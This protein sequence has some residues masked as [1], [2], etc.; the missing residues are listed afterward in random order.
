MKKNIIVAGVL[1]A[2]AAFSGG[3]IY[4]KYSVG[5]ALEDLKAMSAEDRRVALS[6]AGVSGGSMGGGRTA[7]AD[8][9]TGTGRNIQGNNTGEQF[10]N[11]EVL[12]IDEKSLTI[13]TQDGGSKIVYISNETK[14]SK[15]V[16]GALTDIKPQIQIVVT[17]VTNDTGVITAKSI[18]IRDLAP[19]KK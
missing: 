4:G 14:I 6:D 10:M 19:I 17:G 16:S 13:K 18:Q 7:G 5:P 11:G 3:T 15:S 2:I 1:V 12:S 8:A 9:R